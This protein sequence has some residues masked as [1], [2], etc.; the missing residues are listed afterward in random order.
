MLAIRFTIISLLIAFCGVSCAGIEPRWA[1]FRVDDYPPARLHEECL[2]VLS[3]ND[4]QISES[5]SA[6]GKIVSTWQYNL[7][8]FYVPRGQ[9]IGG[10]RRRT[11]IEIADADAPSEE[12]AALTAAGRPLP[13]TVRVRVE[14]ER[15]EERKKP[16]ERDHAI[17]EPDSDDVDLTR[18]IAMMLQNQVRAFE[19]SDDFNRRFGG[20]ATDTK[21]APPKDTTKK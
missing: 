17:W 6:E 18:R 15:N 10:H 11:H 8:P 16:G 21:N 12:I 4:L 14:R 19:P 2:F 7:L 9:G 1:E 3:R 5:D 13:K 20:T